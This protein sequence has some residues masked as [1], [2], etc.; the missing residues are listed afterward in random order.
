MDNAIR[1]YLAKLATEL[2][3]AAHGQSA[4]IIEQ[5]KTFLGWSKDKIYRELKKQVGWTSGRKC[6]ADK[7]TTVM[8]EDS[9]RF[10]AGLEKSSIRKN[11]KQTLHTPLAL[12]VAQQTVW[13]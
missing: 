11:G 1:E 8:A 13:R 7:G 9:L 3:Q 10:I 2:T 6:R 5:A 4:P 12:A